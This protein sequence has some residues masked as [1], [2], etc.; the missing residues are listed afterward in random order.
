MQ[1]PLSGMKN[2]AAYNLLDLPISLLIHGLTGFLAGPLFQHI[3]LS[4][5][6]ALPSHY[7]HSKKPALQHVTFIEIHIYIYIYIY[8]S[9]ASKYV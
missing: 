2:V 3:I 8:T 6:Q 7:S 9:P 1:G 5:I 4:Q